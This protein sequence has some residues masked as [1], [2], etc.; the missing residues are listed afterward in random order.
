MECVRSSSV[1]V[2]NVDSYNPRK[3]NLLGSSVL[4]K[5]GKGCGDHSV[6]DSLM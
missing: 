2:P 5:S 3:R 1:L 6:R 4:S